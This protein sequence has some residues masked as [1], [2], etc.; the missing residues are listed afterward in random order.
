MYDGY[1]SVIKKNK[2]LSFTEKWMELDDIKQDKADM[3]RQV[4]NILFYKWKLKNV[5]LKVE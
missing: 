3:K 4:L 1:N 5:S 2:I